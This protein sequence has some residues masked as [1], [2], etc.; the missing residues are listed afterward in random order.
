MDVPTGELAEKDGWPQTRPLGKGDVEA[1][2]QRDVGD[3]RKELLDTPASA[4]PVPVLMPPTVE[5]VSCQHEWAEF[6]GLELNGQSPDAKGAISD[7]GNTWLFWHH[8]FAA[9][10]LFV[11]RLRFGKNHE[12]ARLKD[13]AAVVL[14]AVKEAQKWKIPTVVIWNMSP[15]VLDAVSY[16]SKE[17]GIGHKHEERAMKLL[18]VRWRAPGDKRQMRF[19]ADEYFMWN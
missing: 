15:E 6:V 18:G 17:L 11:Q 13:I 4:D 9:R 7:D 3:L 2:C 1:L 19:L 12:E 5:L 10:Q 16:L 14:A 8:D